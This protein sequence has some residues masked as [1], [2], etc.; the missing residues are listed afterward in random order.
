MKARYILNIILLLLPALAPAQ[1]R[2]ADSLILVEVYNQLDGPNWNSPDNWLTAAPLEDWKGIRVVNDRVVDLSLLNQG[3]SGNFPSQI[4][5]LDKLQTFEV[6]QGNMTGSIPEGLTALTELSRF[7]VSGNDMSGDVPN[8]WSS[9]EN[10]RFLILQNN[11][12]T[13]TLPD[14]PDGMTLL[15]VDGNQFSGP[16]PAS[17]TGV[18]LSNVNISDNQLTGTMDI[19]STW[20][21]LS[22]MD[23]SD[24]DWDVGPLPMWLDSL[25]NLNSFI[26]SN[27]NLTGSIPAG[28]DLRDNL[29]H[30]QI[31]LSNNNLSGDVATLFIGP[32]STKRLFLSIWNNNFSGS[33]PSHLIHSASS[34]DIRGNNFSALTAFPDSVAFD[35][36]FSTEFNRFNYEALEPLQELIALDGDLEVRYGNMKPTLTADTIV[37]TE[38]MTITLLSGDN[39]PNTTYQWVGPLVQGLTDA[40]VDIVMDESYNGGTYRCI[41][42]NDDYPNL[43]LRRNEV[44]ITTDFSTSV[45]DQLQQGLVV[46]PNPAND[47]LYIESETSL[48]N[49]TYRLIGSAGQVAAAGI[50]GESQSLDLQSLPSGMYTLLVL[51]EDQLLT[52]KIIKL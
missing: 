25:E 42:S 33:F 15:Y 36:R 12:F 13:G 20:P 23:F 31:I 24:N 9:F 16:V 44:V 34:V 22:K 6:R 21:I 52:H 26:C 2:Q 32:N 45:N 18:L 10:L 27:C 37:V 8:I 4:I 7:S 49:R 46:Y 14:I 41:M 29:V 5:G 40:S 50:F 51:S 19:F 43:S 28:F 35:G 1:D 38:P 17:W 11:D 48:E 47:L 30:E 39:H 3:P